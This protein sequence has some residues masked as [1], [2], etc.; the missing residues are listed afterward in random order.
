MAEPCIVQ[1]PLR[2]DIRGVTVQTNAEDTARMRA[3]VRQLLERTPT[4]LTFDVTFR[5]HRKRRTLPQNS[6]LHAR[7]AR[8]SVASGEDFESVK[9]AV[10]M[11]AVKRGYRVRTVLGAVMPEP[12][13]L[14][15]TERCGYLIDECEQIEAEL[16]LP[17]WMPSMAAEYTW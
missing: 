11:R 3:W 17:E 4:D 12:S 14:T 13:H 1:A 9:L 5:P 2:V 16:G 8:I 6:M 10:K 15:D 7:I